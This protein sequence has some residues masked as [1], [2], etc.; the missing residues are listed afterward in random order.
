[1]NY[2]MNLAL[3]MTGAL[4]LI[5]MYFN[6][7][8]RRYSPRRP[9]FDDKLFRL[10]IL[11]NIA[12]LFFDML[13]WI[14]NSS[15]WYGARF[16]NI[17]SNHIYYMLQPA[18][19][20]TWVLY[21][22]YKLTENLPLLAHRFMLYVLPALISEIMVILNL[23][24]PILFRISEDNIY[25]R[26]NVFYGLYTALMLFYI[27]FA[28][29]R[30]LAASRSEAGRKARYKDSYY[31]LM[32]YPLFPCIGLLVQS[33]FY[34][35]AVIWTGS[36]VSLL[37][38]YSNLQNAQI[39]TDVLTGLN[40]R[41]RFQSYISY[42]LNSRSPSGILYMLM[43]D[44]N[45]FKDINDRFGHLAGDETLRIVSRII[46]R[47]IRR[48]DFVA[49][50]GGDEFTVIGDRNSMEDVHKT[51]QIIEAEFAAYNQKKRVPYEVSV[52]IGCSTLTGSETKTPDMLM[53]EADR[54]MYARK[55]AHHANQK[56]QSAG[57]N[58][59]F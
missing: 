26:G 20:L 44:I 56:I 58:A 42:K 32:I 34:G 22:E 18:M 49:R 10:M 7:G 51:V 2:I 17:L 36:M 14:C 33:L 41:H 16:G 6:F 45:N 12:L 43:I 11:I 28:F 50:I 35:V 52:S 21:C 13:S 29:C 39:T 59:G 31:F 55:H 30:V 38:L 46:I 4:I 19:C 5:L 23:F 3:E 40:N 47:C 37:I 25:T 27:L 15:V 9:A 53:A 24:S 54:M 48:N 1:M 57:K 8:N